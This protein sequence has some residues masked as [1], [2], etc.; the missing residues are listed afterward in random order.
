VTIYKYRNKK[1]TTR[2]DSLL[3]EMLLVV[4]QKQNLN[5]VIQTQG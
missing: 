2:K 1:T 4:L 3:V 5:L